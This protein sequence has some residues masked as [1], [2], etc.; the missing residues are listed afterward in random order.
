MKNKRILGMALLSSCLLMGSAWAED[1]GA[2]GGEGHGRRGPGA[3]AG[4]RPPPQREMARDMLQDADANNDC[5]IDDAEAEV[6][7][8]KLGERMKENFKR[9]NELFL[10]QYDEN[11][12]GAIDGA[13]VEKARAA[14]ETFKEN[15]KERVQSRRGAAEAA[16]APATP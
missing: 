12:N 15:L 10:K 6:A 8:K 7:V 16:P 5:I 9:R 2:K 1:D 4:A 3:G 13:E 14:K 11:K